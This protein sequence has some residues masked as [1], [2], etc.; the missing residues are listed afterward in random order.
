MQLSSRNQLHPMSHCGALLAPYSDPTTLVT[1]RSPADSHGLSPPHASTPSHEVVVIVPSTTAGETGRNANQDPCETATTY[2]TTTVSHAGT[3]TKT[4]DQLEVTTSNLL[5]TGRIPDGFLKIQ[6][7]SR[8][9][10]SNQALDDFYDVVTSD[11]NHGSA[12]RKPRE[13]LPRPASCST[14]GTDGPLELNSVVILLGKLENGRLVC[15]TM[16]CHSVQ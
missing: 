5:G 2:L 11:E 8:S 10:A 16:G 1:R 3:C 6:N 12:Q 15:V 9:E 7:Y 4:S 13:H 14:P